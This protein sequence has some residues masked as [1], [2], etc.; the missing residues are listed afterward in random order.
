MI[1]NCTSS[2]IIIQNTGSPQGCVLTP[3]LFILM[4]SDC[5]AHYKNNLV[6]KFAD[7]TAVVG[8]ITQAD[9]SESKRGMEELTGW[10]IS[11]AA[12]ETVS[13]VKYLG[14]HLT[15]SL[16]WRSNTTAVIKKA[17]QQPTSVF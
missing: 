14:V 4:T 8:R 2:T 12:V 15:N 16:T 10:C 11:G 3:L 13:S 6:V 1:N 5:R 9:E 7:D 17:H